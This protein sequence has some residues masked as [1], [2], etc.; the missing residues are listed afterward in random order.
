MFSPDFLCYKAIRLGLLVPN[1]A[2][3][4][5]QKQIGVYAVYPQTRHLPN[6]V[7]SLSCYQPCFQRF[8]ATS[9]AQRVLA[10]NRFS[11]IKHG[12]SDSGTVGKF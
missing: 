9:I 11:G 10:Q 5:V 12:F 2:D 4:L 1:L 7:R 6:R 8:C 3:K